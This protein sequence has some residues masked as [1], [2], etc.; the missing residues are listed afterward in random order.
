MHTLWA[1]IP[2]IGVIQLGKVVQNLFMIL[3]EVI[4]DTALALEG[5]RVGLSSLA[6]VVIAGRTAL[7]FFLLGGGGL[8]AISVTSCCV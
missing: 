5:I 3:A 4:N 2:I 8:C 7:G 1:V 6:E